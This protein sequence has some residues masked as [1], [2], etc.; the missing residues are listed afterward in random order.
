[1]YY[2]S[3]KKFTDWNERDLNSWKVRLLYLLLFFIPKANPDNEKLYPKVKEWLL[4]TNEND[5]PVREIALDKDGNVLFVSPNK[6]NFGFWTDVNGPVRKSEL[7]PIERDVFEDL[8][9]R[10]SRNA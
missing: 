5:Q 10:A 7:S 3:T 6:R 1:M 8:W 4:E 9:Q 2:G